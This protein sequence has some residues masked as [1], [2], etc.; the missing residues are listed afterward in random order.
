MYEREPKA[1]FELPQVHHYLT[2]E[3][4]NLILCK[5]WFRRNENEWTY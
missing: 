3:S 4:K 5:Y 1:E 2:A